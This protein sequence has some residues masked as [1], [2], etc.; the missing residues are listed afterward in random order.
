MAVETGRP[1]VREPYVGAVRRTDET[2]PAFKTS[3]F[4]AYVAIL[5][6]VFI[7]GLIIKGGDDDELKSTT[8]WLY[9]VILTFG[10]M[11]SRGLAKAGSRH[12]FDADARGRGRRRRAARAPAA[13]VPLPRLRRRGAGAGLL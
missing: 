1:A 3:E 7:A 6:G 9:A 11:L 5:L 12:R 13:A 8:V 10:Y 2:K 4:I